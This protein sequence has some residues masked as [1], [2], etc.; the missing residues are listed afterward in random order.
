MASAKLPASQHV[1]H[2][3]QWA[4]KAVKNK[5]DFARIKVAG[6]KRMG[7]PFAILILEIKKDKIC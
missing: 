1:K 6:Q 7:V 4:T 5:D 2:R 3:V